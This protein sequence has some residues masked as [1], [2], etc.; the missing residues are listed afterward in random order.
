MNEKIT[1][2]TKVARTMTNPNPSN[3]LP[4]GREETHRYLLHFPKVLWNRMISHGLTW[5]TI[6]KF[7]IEA[8]T[9]K[10]DREEARRK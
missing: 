4:R 8:V 10:L 3:K 2:I 7:V 1:L 6:R 5:G 9:E